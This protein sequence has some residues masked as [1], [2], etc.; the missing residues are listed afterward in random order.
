MSYVLSADRLENAW[1]GRD[2]ENGWRTFLDSRVPKTLLGDYGTSVEEVA[3][4]MKM[5]YWDLSPR[6]EARPL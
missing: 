5:R 1:A 2:M 3:L 6:P 4:W